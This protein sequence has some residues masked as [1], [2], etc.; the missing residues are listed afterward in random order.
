MLDLL[1]CEDD[2]AFD[3][4]FTL[5]AKTTSHTEKYASADQIVK[6]ANHGM[7]CGE[8]YRVEVSNHLVVVKDYEIT[9]STTPL[10]FLPRAEHSCKRLSSSEERICLCILLKCLVI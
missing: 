3:E 8:E 5:L 9:R 4:C 10:S 6:Y 2:T 1:D 7:Y